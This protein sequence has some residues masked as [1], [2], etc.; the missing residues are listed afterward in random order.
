MIYRIEQDDSSNRKGFADYTYRIYEHN[1]LVAR[2][3]HDYRGDEYGLEFVDKTMDASDWPFR[4]WI[5][6]VDGES[7]EL[8]LTDD[9]IAYLLRKLRK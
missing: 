4:S 3:W 1:R 7:L 9:A 6:F 8:K 2:L 5:G